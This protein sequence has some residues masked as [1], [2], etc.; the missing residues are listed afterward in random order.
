MNVTEEK[1]MEMLTAY[2]HE[3][4]ERV[5][6]T[7]EEERIPLSRTWRLS[8]PKPAFIDEG[9]EPEMVFARGNESLFANH[10]HYRVRVGSRIHGDMTMSDLELVLDPFLPPDSWYIETPI[11]VCEPILDAP[12]YGYRLAEYLKQPTQSELEQA[13]ASFLRI[14]NDVRYDES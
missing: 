10:T 1:L 6:Y 7:A 11:G 8:S 3:W 14:R 5:R 2:G 4:R 9:H 12:R 13:Y